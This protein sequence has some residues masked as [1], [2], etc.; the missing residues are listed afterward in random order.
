MLDSLLD[1]SYIYYGGLIY[2]Q[3]KGISQCA[4]CSQQL[5]G[6]TLAYMNV[7]SL[8]ET[9]PAKITLMS[10][11]TTALTDTLMIHLYLTMQKILKIIS[12]ES[13]TLLFY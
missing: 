2:K 6:L 10:V 7:S 11:Y 1:S 12:K 9:L 13:I 3:V 4:S 5:A 8:A